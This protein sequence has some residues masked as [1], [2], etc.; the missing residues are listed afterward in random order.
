MTAAATALVVVPAG[1]SAADS[2]CA[3]EQRAG[4]PVT[5]T[6]KD[7]GFEV[8]IRQEQSGVQPVSRPH[9]PRAP[10][11]PTYVD[12][13]LAP[14]CTGNSYFDGGVLCNAAVETCP[15]G[16]IR[17]WV[18]EATIQRSTGKPVAGTGP[19]L[20]NT[21][22]LGPEDAPLDPAVAL[23]AVVQREFQSVVV[24]SG[25]AQVSPAPETLVN[26]PTRF[27]TDAPASYTIPMT[28]LNQ[29]VVITATAR[30]YL[31]TV[32]EGPQLVSTQPNG[33]LEHTYATSGSREVWVDIEWSG[34][35]SVN[36]GPPRPIAGTVV[37]EGEPV[38][39]EVREARSELVRD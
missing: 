20:V 28:L 11:S 33:Y 25:T 8:E 7:N 6:A 31:W 21:V 9:G 10:L 32:G 5:G 12:R 29:S 4:C 35:F 15:E 30:R 36:G 19:R 22:C 1:Q 23:P 34:T 17:F 3:S 37:T 2:G 16:E 38:P 18:F 24:L 14:T 39:V 27:Q 26:V 13:N